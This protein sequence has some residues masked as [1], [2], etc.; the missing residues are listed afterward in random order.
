V[1]SEI[2]TNSQLSES[3]YAIDSAMKTLQVL[4]AFR[5]SPHTFTIAEMEQLVGLSKNQVFRCLKSMEEFGLVRIDQHGRYRVT[6]LIYQIAFAGE[7]EAPL[8][9]VAQPV[10]DQLQTA[11]GETVN[12]CCMVEGQSVIVAR[13]NSKHGVRLTV[14]LG[15]RIGLHAG[16]NPKAMLAFLPTEDQEQVLSMLPLLQKY[17][18]KTVT[19]PDAL[20]RELEEIRHRGYSI[21]NED[22]EP[23]AIGVGA[24]I[25]GREGNVVGGI[26]AGGPISRVGDEQME[27]FGEVTMLAA[28]RISRLLGHINSRL[29]NITLT[30]SKEEEVSK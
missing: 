5:H 6:P 7:V 29:D 9:E 21:S 16:A 1:P 20:R 18:D 22:F 10:M 2:V 19:N 12:L 3:K 28:N 25:F 4:F 8:E 30:D 23:G 26:S 24:P 11:T 14:R 17:T 13:R 15:E 27:W